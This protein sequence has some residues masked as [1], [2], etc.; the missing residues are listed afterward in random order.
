M[1]SVAAPAE[2]E[3]P[4]G[5][6]ALSIHLGTYFLLASW[7]LRHLYRRRGI[8]AVLALPI[9]WSGV[10]WVRSHGPLGFPWFL[11]GHSQIQL[12]TVIQIAYTLDRVVVRLA[13]RW[14][15]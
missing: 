6:V 5:Y 7:L 12:P 15:C 9:V 8:R 13:R 3:V 2:F 11:L 4:E 1:T 10:E 14:S